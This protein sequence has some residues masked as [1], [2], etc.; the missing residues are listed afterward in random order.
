[1]RLVNK[2]CAASLKVRLNPWIRR[3][4]EEGRIYD[5]SDTIEHF[6]TGYGKF[7]EPEIRYI[8]L[9][10]NNLMRLN[11][12][13]EDMANSALI[14]KRLSETVRQTAYIGSLLDL[15]L[16]VFFRWHIN[17]DLFYELRC[18]S[19]DYPD[20]LEKRVYSLIRYERDG[21]RFEQMGAYDALKVAELLDDGPIVPDPDD[22][23]AN[24]RQN[25]GKKMLVRWRHD[26]F[27]LTS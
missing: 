15:T 6:R 21:L 24:F 25:R 7:S 17:E 20:Y 26:V 9:P 8:F 19:K 5:I 10:C 3:A 4:W 27:G 23:W 1:M 12:V 11:R 2:M 18:Q 13:I 14:T 16:V 22:S